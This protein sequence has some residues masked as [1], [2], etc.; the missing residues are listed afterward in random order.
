MKADRKKREIKR[1]SDA[2]DLLRNV[3]LSLFSKETRVRIIDAKLAVISAA[4]DAI[5]E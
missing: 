4:L 1:L 3:D 2:C 5:L